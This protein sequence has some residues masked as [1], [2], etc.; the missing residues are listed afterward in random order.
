ML[1]F[2]RDCR[3][4]IV[5]A[6]VSRRQRVSRTSSFRSFRADTPAMHAYLFMVRVGRTTALPTDIRTSGRLKPRPCGNYCCVYFYVDYFV[7]RSIVDAPVFRAF[8]LFGLFLEMRPREWQCFYWVL[9]MNFS[10][11]ERGEEM[12][13]FTLEEVIFFGDNLPI[14]ILRS[15]RW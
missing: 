6:C 13:N 4:I 9:K 8:Q 5:N 2:A 10:Y 15:H 1:F 7:E 11:V 3:V 12:L 14:E